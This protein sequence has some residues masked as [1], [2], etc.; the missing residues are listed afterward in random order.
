M[1]RGLDWGLASAG[2]DL[3]SAGLG[4]ASGDALVRS[5]FSSALI[6]FSTDG[7]VGAS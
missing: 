3:A 1:A 5:T 6:T 4:A 2:P 7:F